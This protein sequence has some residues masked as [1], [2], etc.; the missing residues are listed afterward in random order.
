VQRP[1]T[2]EIALRA[3]RAAREIHGSDT[4]VSSQRPR[5]V[6][7]RRMPTFIAPGKESSLYIQLYLQRRCTRVMCSL[8]TIYGALF[9]LHAHSSLFHVHAGTPAS[10]IGSDWR[11]SQ[12]GKFSF[13]KRRKTWHISIF[14]RLATCARQRRSAPLGRSDTRVARMEKEVEAVMK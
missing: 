4:H 7:S 12:R 11:F 6:E 10:R 13:P 3:A 1:A 9:C 8:I 2:L 14:R 5:L